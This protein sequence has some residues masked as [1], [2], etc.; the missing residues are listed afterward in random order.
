MS[1]TF[2]IQ[3]RRP[4]DTVSQVSPV[5]PVYDGGLLPFAYPVWPVGG[6]TGN[7]ALQSPTAIPVFAES[8]AVIET[9]TTPML[10]TQSGMEA[11]YRNCM[12]VVTLY[13][14]SQSRAL[15]TTEFMLINAQL[16]SNL[17]GSATVLANAYPDM[18]IVGGTGFDPTPGS[19]TLAQKNIVFPTMTGPPSTVANTIGLRII[20][21]IVDSQAEREPRAP[22]TF[23]YSLS[24]AV[25]V[26]DPVAG[27][28]ANY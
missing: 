24:G 18:A 2:P 3:I 27:P 21:L 8:A 15:G 17:Y 28:C 10:V 7:P 4:F 25:A 23:V 16:M 6:S 13:I 12:G 11:Q 14:E 9:G 22:F 19:R 1:D 26:A 20:A 5:V